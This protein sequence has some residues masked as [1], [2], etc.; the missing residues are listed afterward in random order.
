MSGD[1]EQ[2]I[3]ETLMRLRIFAAALFMGV[4]IMTVV[5]LFLL[6]LA[7]LK[8]TPPA[9]PMPAI[10][11][12]FAIAQTFLAFVMKSMLLRRQQF[13]DRDPD[14]VVPQVLAAYQKATLVSMALCEGGA[15]F[16]IVM[17]FVG[18]GPLGWFTGVV[19]PVAGMVL[20]FPTRVAID[21]II[22]DVRRGN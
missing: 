9:I 7:P 15:F 12:A 19:V 17:V 1:A 16:A 10:G 2:K 21:Q 18:G 22:Q 11:L 5:F 14:R 20:L 13:A 8:N 6:T 3:N 4:V